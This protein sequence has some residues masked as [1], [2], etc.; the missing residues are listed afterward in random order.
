[1]ADVESLVFHCGTKAE[2]GRIVTA[3]GRVLSVT[4]LGAT[5][6]AAVDNAYARIAGISFDGMFYRKDIAH[7]AFARG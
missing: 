4:G 6:R 7:R 5:L 3:G 2:G 1:M